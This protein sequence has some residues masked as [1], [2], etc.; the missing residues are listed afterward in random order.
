MDARSGLAALAA[1]PEGHDL[2]AA[3][4]SEGL[5]PEQIARIERRLW[6]VKLLDGAMAAYVVSIQPRWANELFGL[7]DTLFERASL[8]GLSREHVYYRS[9]RGNPPAP[10]RLLWYASKQGPDGIGAVVAT[11]QLVEVVTDTPR[12]LFRRYAHLGV[13]RLEDIEARAADGVAS[14]LRFVDTE[15]FP[16]PVPLDRLRSLGAV[17][18]T[19]PLLS[20]TQVE[21]RAYGLV[22]EEGTGR[23]GH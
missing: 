2:T 19:A 16:R 5:S 10:A 3:M 20:P 23:H 17:S 4:G 7:V 12:R 15:R 9:R 18:R 1:L 6:P 13:Y 11:S 21:P 8:L 14:A 22:Y